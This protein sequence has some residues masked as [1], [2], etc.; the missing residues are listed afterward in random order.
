MGTTKES[1]ATMFAKTYME[2]CYRGV[3]GFLELLCEK[4]GLVLNKNCEIIDC[5]GR[6]MLCEYVVTKDIFENAVF[7]RNQEQNY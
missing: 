2:K 7:E 1:L 3:I 5:D 4:C 6:D